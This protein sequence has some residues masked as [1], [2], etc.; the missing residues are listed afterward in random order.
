MPHDPEQ[1]RLAGQQ[2]RKH[3][4]YSLQDR[5]P[6]ALEPAERSRYQELRELVKSQPGREEFREELLSTTMLIVE[7]G[8][9]ELRHTNDL[10]QSIW[11]VPVIKALASYINSAARLIDSFPK[12]DLKSVRMAQVVEEMKERAEAME[13]RD[14][15]AQDSQDREIDASGAVG[16]R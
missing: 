12:D 5:G 16:S 15:K 11:T 6:E 14:Q 8:V 10:G 2:G 4:I 9:S 7:M 3:G 13:K 1:K